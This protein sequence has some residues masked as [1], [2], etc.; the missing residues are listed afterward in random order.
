MQKHY[1]FLSSATDVLKT[2]SKTA[3]QETAEATGDLIGNKIAG[4]IIKASKTSRW[5]S[6]ERVTNEA[7]NI[8]HDKEILLKSYISP[9]KRLIYKI[10]RYQIISKIIDIRSLDIR[11][12]I[13]I[14]V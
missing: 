12:K 3:I 10:I 5:S 1:G 13:N 8:E 6:S 7:E 9:G 11:C 2:A 4:K 14:M